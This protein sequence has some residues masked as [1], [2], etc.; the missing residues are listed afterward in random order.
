MYMKWISNFLVLKSF[1]YILNQEVW[2][3]EW[4]KLDNYYQDI[5]AH[6]EVALFLIQDNLII[7]L[8]IETTEKCKFNIRYKNTR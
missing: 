3:T 1:F 6:N 8:R 4:Q 7:Y 2:K 5:H